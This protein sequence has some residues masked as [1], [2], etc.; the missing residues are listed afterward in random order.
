MAVGWGSRLQSWL[1]RS[2]RY[3]AY[4]ILV[5]FS[6]VTA[7]FLGPQFLGVGA[8]SREASRRVAR[9]GESGKNNPASSVLHSKSFW[10]YKVSRCFSVYLSFN[11]CQLC[12][13]SSSPITGWYF[14]PS[15]HSCAYLISACCLRKVTIEYT[16]FSLRRGRSPRESWR[17]VWTRREP[18]RR[19]RDRFRKEMGEYREMISV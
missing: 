2:S 17:T 11:K 3:V 1:L 19:K 9:I 10:F 5:G 6:Q 18:E 13:L 12:K 4:V 15:L 16:V 7:G 8:R 14:S